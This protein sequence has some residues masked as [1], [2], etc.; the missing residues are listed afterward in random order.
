MLTGVL[1]GLAAGALWGL[2][3]V[4]PRMVAGYSSVDLAAG[5]FAAYGVLA[6]AVMLLSLLAG[7]RR[8]R[9]PTARQALTALGMS[10]L[11]FSGYY[12]L[13]VLAI[14]DAGT[15]VPTLVIGTI[16]VWVMLLGK[17]Q[18]LR[19]GA[20]VPGLLLTLAGLL[21]MMGAT[22][23]GAADGG[24]HY[25]R[26]IVLVTVSLVSWTAF[27]ILNS[28]WLKRHP[29]VN[30]TDWANWLGV[31]TGLGAVVL[32]W[33]AGS[34]ARTLAAQ[35]DR[36][37]FS[38]LCIA[39]GFGSAWLATILWNIASQRLSASLCGQ[40]IVSVTIFALLYS[41]AWDGHWPTLAQ[42]LAC[43]LFTL[44]ILASI[45]AHR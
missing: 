24:A 41:F 37:A 8:R 35:D 10:V 27:A 30:A 13:L 4:A 12:L 20:L 3:F 33:V 31:E 36:A 42:S 11:G 34:D 15:E 43:L 23:G 18:H 29:E 26:G 22:H 44:G 6:A 1:A 28:A 32:W 7:K 19:W 40:L 39:T 21:L 14:R 2:V 5:R 17:P 25:W 38:L 45:R 9:L 16:P